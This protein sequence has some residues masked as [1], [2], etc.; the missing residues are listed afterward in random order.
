VSTFRLEPEHFHSRSDRN[1]TPHLTTGTFNLIVKDRI[2]GPPE[3]WRIQSI[4]VPRHRRGFVCPR[5]LLT[6]SR[7][8]ERCQPF[9]IT[10]FP[11][12]F[13][14][15]GSFYPITRRALLERTRLT[16]P[17]WKQTVLFGTRRSGRRSD[18]QKIAWRF[19]YSR[20][21]FRELCPRM[22]TPELGSI[23]EVS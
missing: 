11:P 18:H 1:R 13:H 3:R 23:L 2:T 17:L 6:V 14:S 8:R 5:N 16:L 9:E 7:R 12:D 4:R 19:C 21:P 22:R 15:K 10:G 20:K